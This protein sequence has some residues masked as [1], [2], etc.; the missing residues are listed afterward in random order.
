[1]RVFP[2]LEVLLKKELL[3]NRKIGLITNH[4]G[5]NFNLESNFDLMLRAGYKMT[6]LFSPEHGIYGDH[7]DGQYVEGSTHTGTGIPIHSL[8]GATQKP[9]KD[10][11]KN[12]DILVFDIQ[13][14][15][16]RYYTYMSTMILSME[17][18]SENG[19]EF[20]ILDRPNPIGGIK[21]E[22]NVTRPG[23][24]SSVSY[25]PVSI[26]HGMTAG[27]IGLFMA[28]QK[29]L[30]QPKVIAM[31]GWSRDMYFNET[32]FPWVPTSPSAPTLEMAILYP[33]TCLLEGTNLSEG[34]GTSTPFQTLG[35]PW[36]DGFKL[37]EELNQMGIPGIR[38]RP[39]YF[40]PSFSKWTGDICQGVQIHIFE[41][42]DINP[43]ELGVRLLFAVRDLYP[44]DFRIIP[45]GPSGKHFLDLLCGGT[46]LAEALENHDSPDGLL[47]SWREEAE[48]FSAKRRDFLIY[49]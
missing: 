30:P 20:A 24:I 49:T 35:A 36:V 38:T 21:V 25:A 39:V 8:Y 17:A 12:V 43:V 33:G 32:G 9:K 45:P 7:P 34:R 44:D 41:P 19:I 5:N 2:G 46:Q 26:R 37:S 27:E 3:K 47:N 18:A 6:A 4:T 23:W 1:M 48:H 28:A 13:D 10:M 40:R 15:G 29:G 42:R 31:E 14:I 22:G 11:L 16:A